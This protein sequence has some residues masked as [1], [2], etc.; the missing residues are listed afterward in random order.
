MDSV[1]FDLPRRGGYFPVGCAGVRRRRR[2]FGVLDNGVCTKGAFGYGG[3]RLGCWAW[4]F[5]FRGHQLL[6][7]RRGMLG[8]VGAPGGIGYLFFGASG[9]CNHIAIHP[10]QNKAAQSLKFA[11]DSKPLLELRI[12]LVA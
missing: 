8:C 6:S 3:V 10:S 1:N 7:Q 5:A 9:V 2:A 11:A 12:A 4:R